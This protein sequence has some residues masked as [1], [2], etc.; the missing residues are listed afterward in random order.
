MEWLSGL[1]APF[2]DGAPS[3]DILFDGPD[4]RPGI[5]V[6]GTWRVDRYD[7]VDRDTAVSHERERDEP[8]DVAMGDE[9]VPVVKAIE[10]V[11]HLGVAPQA[12]IDAGAVGNTSLVA[13]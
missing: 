13:G 6:I 7:L 5:V 4:V 12:S 1:P 8:T 10:P 11:I 3:I 2:I 9:P